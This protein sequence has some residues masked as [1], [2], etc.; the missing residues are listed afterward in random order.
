[1]AGINIKSNVKSNAT[2][3]FDDNVKRRNGTMV[4]ENVGESNNPPKT[5][6][7]QPIR[8]GRTEIISPNSQS[9]TNQSFSMQELD[10]APSINFIEVGALI[11]HLGK[12]NLPYVLREGKNVIGRDVDCNVCLSRLDDNTISRKHAIILYRHGKFKIEEYPE[13]TNNDVFLN[14]DPLEE[15]IKVI[16][17][18]DKI[19]LGQTFFTFKDYR[20]IA[21]IEEAEK[22]VEDIEKIRNLIE[23]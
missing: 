8:S 23:D 13:R 5:I 4:P 1:M 6:H 22:T 18:G 21:Q 2:A 7:V 19:R 17:D 11:A 15:R 20:D 14:E 16:Q 10:T 9:D 12:A 3:A